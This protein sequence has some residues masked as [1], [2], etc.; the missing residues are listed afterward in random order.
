[1]LAM[2]ARTSMGAE[3]VAIS[4]RAEALFVSLM[5]NTSPSAISCR[6]AAAT[7]CMPATLRTARAM[8]DDVSTLAC[9]EITHII[10]TRFE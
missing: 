4:C 1:M 2:Y 3:P 5:R 6:A 10:Q 9:M 7:A 8:Q